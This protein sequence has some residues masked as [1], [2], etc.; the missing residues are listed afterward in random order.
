MNRF[1]PSFISSLDIRKVESTTPALLLYMVLDPR[2]MFNSTLNVRAQ[3][4]EIRPH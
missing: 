4:Q 1:Q 2:H 3:L